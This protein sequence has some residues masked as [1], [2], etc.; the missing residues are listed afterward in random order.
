MSITLLASQRSNMIGQM[1]S[2]S[3]RLFETSKR[4]IKHPSADSTLIPQR[5]ASPRRMFPQNIN[6]CDNNIFDLSGRRPIELSNKGVLFTYDFLKSQVKQIEKQKENIDSIKQ[7]EPRGIKTLPHYLQEKIDRDNLFTSRENFIH[8]NSKVPLKE[9]V[10]LPTENYRKCI[11]P[12]AS[13]LHSPRNTSVNK[14][15]MREA[16]QEKFRFFYESP[17]PTKNKS[18]NTEVYIPSEKL[19]NAIL[20][21]IPQNPQLAKENDISQSVYRSPEKYTLGNQTTKPF[22]RK[23]SLSC[24]ASEEPCEDSRRSNA[25]SVQGYYANSKMRAQE[26]TEEILSRESEYRYEQEIKSLENERRNLEK[27]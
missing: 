15:E 23:K 11:F 22:K 14:S 25:K 19:N 10:E 5:A 12:F 17:S 3:A 1:N 21:D 18:N 27:N 8:R 4:H 2:P 9:S 26:V 7:Q 16:L 20:E 6:N 13:H 24:G